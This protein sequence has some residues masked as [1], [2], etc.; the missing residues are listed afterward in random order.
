MQESKALPLRPARSIVRSRRS[1]PEPRTFIDPDRIA[2][3][4]GILAGPSVTFDLAA[5]LPSPLGQGRRQRRKGQRPVPERAALLAGDG[6]R[7]GGDVRDPDSRF[8]SVDVL[9]ART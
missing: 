1:T 2:P 8:R 6:D 3:L 5:R 4:Q 9:T 7:S